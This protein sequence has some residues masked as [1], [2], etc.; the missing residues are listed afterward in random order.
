MYRQ[1]GIADYFMQRV[2]DFARSAN[3][4]IV[5]TIIPYGDMNL[6]QLLRFFENFGFEQ[7][8]SEDDLALVVFK[9]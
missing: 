2:V 8:E 3:L 7:Q 6:H 1:R 4:P 5:N 9:P